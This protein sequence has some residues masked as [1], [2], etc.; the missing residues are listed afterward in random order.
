MMWV[1]SL[2]DILTASAIVVL[3]VSRDE[4]QTAELDKSNDVQVISDVTG[5]WAQ[6]SVCIGHCLM[7]VYH[8]V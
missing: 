4:P 6:A 7:C 3:D 5:V 2:V 1:T 8:R